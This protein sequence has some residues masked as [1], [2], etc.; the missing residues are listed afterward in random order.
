MNPRNS[1]WHDVPALSSYITRTQSILQS[2]KPDND[3]LFYWPIYD[4]WHSSSGLGMNF[5]VHSME[6]SI[7]GTP[8]G[9]LARSLWNAGF[10]FDYISDLQISGANARDGS[11]DVP[12]GSYRAIV[13]PSTQHMPTPTVRN[14][15][16]LARRGSTIIFETL[17][18]DVPG[19]KDFAARQEELRQ[20]VN[21]LALRESGRVKV[22]A[23]GSGK[24]IVG[25]VELALAVAGIRPEPMVK[26][27]GLN[28]VRLKS[29][30]VPYY[31]IVNRGRAI[32]KWVA[33]GAATSS[34][35]LMDPLTGRFGSA[36]LRQVSGASEIYLQIQPG[37][38]LILSLD[39]KLAAAASAW[40]Y[41]SAAGSATELNGQW[42]AE[43]ISGGPELPLSQRLNDLRSWT[44]FGGAAERFAG[45]ARYTFTFDAPN[46]SSAQG[47][48]LDLGNVHES[49]R[50]RI[51]GEDL[52]TLLMPPYRLLLPLLKPSGNRLEIE[53]T[54]LTAN[55]IRDLDR[56]GI[57][58]RKF[59][60]I[61]FVNID[62]QKFDA[63]Q[64]PL[65]PSGLLG[66]V[67]LQS[68]QPLSPAPH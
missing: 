47:W 4:Y 45:T 62:Y 41:R 17:P 66:P 53:V 48:Q 46:N 19:W 23:V 28:F 37:H 22:A 68:T 5:T 44:E 57:P 34:V 38:S 3:I 27:A 61:N 52:G 2:A 13:V 40:E 6:N 29:A 16:E 11:I 39:P 65:L 63:S 25:D 7:K 9:N 31:F 1:I 50:V 24:V 54:N 51:N 56:R 35:L 20:L 55:R 60:D 8:F 10:A 14:L 33:L 12:G 42:S 49:A 67:T 32:D 36:A 64:W 59:R 26:A 15:L 43:F 58:W 21:P 18:T 30:G